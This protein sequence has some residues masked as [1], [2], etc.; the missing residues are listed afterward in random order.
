M[1]ALTFEYPS[2]FLLFCFGTG[3]LLSALLY[4][5]DRTFEEYPPLATWGLAALRFLSIS[6]LCALLLS[7][8]LRFIQQETQEPIVVFAQDASE[9]L[10]TMGDDTVSYL[11]AR[12]KLLDNLADAY[13]LRTYAF[14]AEFRPDDTLRFG[15]KK[16]NLSEVLQELDDLYANQN[17]GAV[18]LASDGIYN[19]GSNPAYV[20]TQLNTPIYTIAL[21]DTTRRK[22]VVL[23]RVFHNRI[24]YLNDRFTIQVDV[25]AIN[26]N[27]A[28]TQ[29]TVS[30][31]EGGRSRELERQT[32]NIDRSD[33]FRSFDFILDADESGV[34]R[35]R[36]EVSSIDGEQNRNNNVRD[37]FI[38][39]LDA[40]QKILVLANAPHPDLSALKQSLISGQNNEVDVAYANTFRGQIAAYDLLILHQLPSRRFPIAPIL[41][42]ATAQSKPIWYIAGELTQF[43]QLARIQNLITINAGG[44]QTNDV[45]AQL[46]GSFSLFTLSEELRGLIPN[47]PPLEAPFGEFAPGGD[48]SVLFNQRIGRIETPYPLLALGEEGENRKAL[49]L[50]TGIWRWRLFDY[51]EHQNHERFNELISQ[52]TQYLSIKEDK[53]RF[54]V[55]L[56]KNIFDE[57]EAITLDAELYNDNYELVNGPDV[58]ITI[59]DDS[60]RDYDYTFNRTGRSYS[61]NAGILPVG[62]YRYQARTNTG[63]ETLTFD[64]Q[65]SIRPIQIELVETTADHALLRLLSDQ[66]GGDLLYPEQLV[67]LPQRLQDRGTV[68]PVL[69]QT[70][71]TESVLNLKWIFALLLFLLTAEWFLRRYFGAY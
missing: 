57:N 26:S 13:D 62:N 23:S 58:T 29:L 20:N 54:R 49:L 18:I 66:S 71:R 28:T 32:L 68:K 39:I 35:Y 53:R 30:K 24:A 21:G 10:I 65:F 56:P 51:L 46:N 50:G 55:T 14:G 40:R 42:S 38:D 69:Y 16:T 12:Q 48:G 33:F 25:Q 1:Q 31:I 6:L 34:Q 15:D 61:L 36:I 63:T 22:D 70:V 45:Q 52:L 47:F 9:S 59:T 3:L 64:G 8:L 19:E 2:W 60:G 43:N 41:Q 67:E 17:V 37:I 11:E 5:R 27:G 4:W 7:P 44:R